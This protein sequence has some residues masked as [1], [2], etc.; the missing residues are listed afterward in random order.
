VA[1]ERLG[2][3]DKKKRKDQAREVKNGIKTISLKTP[4]NYG[5]LGGGRDR[6]S[7]AWS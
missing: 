3:A 2:I 6:H 4:D 1:D 5:L 7:K